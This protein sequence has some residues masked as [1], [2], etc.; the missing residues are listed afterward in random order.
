MACTG[1][2]DWGLYSNV[3]DDAQDHTFSRGIWRS[4][5]IQEVDAAPIIHHVVPSTFYL[6]PYATSPL[7]DSHH[8]GFNLIV[9]S[10]ISLTQAVTD[11]EARFNFGWSTTPVTAGFTA[12][13]GE[14][15]VKHSFT[16]SA[17][18][19]K[20]WWPR[21]TGEQ[22]LYNV[23]VEL[24]TSKSACATAT[25]TIGFRTIALVTGNDT[26]PE[27]V[28]KNV[29]SEG[30]DDH[31]MMFRVNGAA[32]WARGANM[33]PMDALEVCTPRPSLTLL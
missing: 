17:G 24:C 21:F 22:H 16:V 29:N 9:E 26:D 28:Q 11:G 3:Y 2:W 5:Y 7:V 14:A 10:H 12:G 30:S 32:I 8:A 13:A 19:I 23:T 18:D 6:G 27:Y 4:V 1:G 33:I 20:L 25:R 31:G 15:V